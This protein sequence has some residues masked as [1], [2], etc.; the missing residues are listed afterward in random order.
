MKPNSFLDNCALPLG[1]CLGDL[2]AMLLFVA[3]G[4]HEHPL[5][6][7]SDPLRGLLSTMGIFALPWLLAGWQLRV[8]PSRATLEIR[9][10]WVRSVNAW[11]VAAPLA[12][13]LRAYVLGRAV[14]PTVFITA[15]VLFGGLFL[16]GWRA[17]FGL[18][19]QARVRAGRP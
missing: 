4:Q 17:V 2:I 10:L 3:I 5:A 6:N 9:L 13:L 16:L 12:I 7:A 11:L 18:A 14:V 8:F 15:T 19:W 1:L